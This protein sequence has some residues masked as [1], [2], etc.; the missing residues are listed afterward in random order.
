MRSIKVALV[1]VG[2]LAS[3]FV[4]GLAYYEDP[5]KQGELLHP[6]IAG[7]TISDMEVV[8]AFDIDERKVGKD[9]SEAIFADPNKMPQVVDLQSLGVEVQKG[10]TLDGV[11]E[12]ATEVIHVSNKPD[13]DVVDV[14]KRSEAEV[15]VIA[16]PSGAVETCEHYVNAALEAGCAVIN[17]SPTPIARDKKWARKFFE[18][19]L[20]ILG[21]DLQSQSGGTAFHKGLLKLLIELGVSV[22][23]TYQLDVS[24][25]LEGLTTLDFDRRHY[26]RQVK[27]QSI[28]RAIDKPINVASGT[29]DY[30][31]FLGTLRI[32]HYWVAGST[33]LDQPIKIDIRMETLDGSNGAATLVDAVRLAKIALNRVLGGPIGSVSAYLFKAP[34]LIMPHDEAKAGFEDFI[35]GRRKY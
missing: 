32:G 9:L 27:E 23:D 5:H 30:L 20:P 3:G 13:V 19:R 35:L 33:F 10:P 8:A 2:N 15:V 24:G 17:A 12:T 28:S 18:A 31:D 1:G 26:K 4:Q 34:P 7:L 6:K 29:T 14:L 11:A 25:G 16:T 21:D 22:D